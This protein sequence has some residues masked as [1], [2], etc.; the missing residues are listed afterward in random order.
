[1]GR[2]AR[3]RRTAVVNVL[4]NLGKLLLEGWLGLIFSST[5]LLADAVDSVADLL[6]A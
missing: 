3:Y 5:A 1:M 4:G 6:T 2:A